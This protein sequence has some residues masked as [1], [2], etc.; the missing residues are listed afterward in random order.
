MG[1]PYEYVLTLYPEEGSTLIG[2]LAITRCVDW[3]PAREWTVFSAIRRAG[4]LPQ[5]QG[6]IEETIRPLW[7]PKAGQP[8]LAGFRVVLSGNGRAGGNDGEAFSDFPTAYFQALAQQASAL[9]VEKGKL[10]AGGHF[11]Y[12]VTAYPAKADSQALS[13]RPAKAAFD[14]EEVE[15]PLALKEQP[16]AVALGESVPYDEP[17]PEKEDMPLFIPQHVL[18]ETAALTRRAGSNETGG[19]LIGYL[20]SDKS[21]PE[22]YVQVT[23]QIPARHTRANLTKLTFTPDTWTAVRSALEIRRR[24]EIWVGWWHSHSYQKET[25]KTCEKREDER[26]KASATFMSADDLALHRTVFPK[27]YSVALVVSDSPCSGLTWA[28]FGWNYGMIA[29]RSF[30]IV[31]ASSVAAC[32]DAVTSILG[33]GEAHAAK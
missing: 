24:D 8:Y 5:T 25:C 9:Y 13:P 26:C 23:D 28:L 14:V 7:H 33:E 22:V 17:A 18:E 12:L 2:R 6:K 27:A 4:S 1:N 29:P 30:H 16:L 19:V 3:E 15:P 21:R 31:G 32:R 10:K 20:H 11:R